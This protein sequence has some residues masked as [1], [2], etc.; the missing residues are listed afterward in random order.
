M[1][2][3]RF[4]IKDL[5]KRRCENAGGHH[6][7]Q[8]HHLKHRYEKDKKRRGR[9]CSK[10]LG[11]R[12]IQQWKILNFGASVWTKI[13]AISCNRM[14][15][16]VFIHLSRNRMSEDW[17]HGV[18][19]YMS[20]CLHRS[21]VRTVAGISLSVKTSGTLKFRNDYIPD[22][23]IQSY[24]NPIILRDP[25]WPILLR[26][27]GRP[28]QLHARSAFLEFV[29]WRSERKWVTV[30]KYEIIVRIWFVICMHFSSRI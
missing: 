17:E 29:E 21:L 7:W 9:F 8:V 2:W 28:D 16:S 4:Q 24:Q 10:F 19:L 14:L 15:K 13:D 30:S 3:L 26:F 27:A 1:A 11:R 23:G 20:L 5:Q 25:L 18:N 22:L 12:R 6:F